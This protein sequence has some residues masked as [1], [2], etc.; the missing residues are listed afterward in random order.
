MKK[1]SNRS[2]FVEKVV[3]GLLTVV[4]LTACADNT[5]EKDSSQVKEGVPV[6]VNLQFQTSTA[7]RVTTRAL[8]EKGEFQV[9]DLYLLIFDKN[10]NRKEGSIYY[11]TEALAGF[12]HTAGNQANPTHGTITNLKTTSGQSY[13]FGIANVADNELDRGNKLKTQLDNMPSLSELKKW[14]TTLNND[15]NIARSSPSLLMSGTFQAT[16]ATDKEKAE[17]ICTIPASNGKISGKLNLRRLDSHITFNIKLGEK[18]QIFEL[19]SWQVY[20][21]PVNSF[22]IDQ[23]TQFAEARYANSGEQKEYSNQSDESVFSFDF[24]MQ[25]NLKRAFTDK[26]TMD[27]TVLTNYKDREKEM[28]NMDGSNSGIYKYVEANATYVEIKAKMNIQPSGDNKF[29]TADVRYIVHLGGGETDYTNFNSLRNKKYTYTVTI[30]DVESIIV[31]VK[32]GE[33]APGARP[34]SEGDVVD[35][36]T[37][38]YALDSHYSCFNMGFTYED[39]VDNLSFIVQTPFAPDAVYSTKGAIGGLA[40]TVQANGDYKWIEF[41]RAED[42]NTLAKYKRDPIGNQTT[43]LT[44]YDLEDDMKKQGKPGDGKTYYYTVFIDEYYYDEAP[45]EIAKSNW[46]NPL[47]KNFVNKGNRKLLLF[48]ETQTS[49]DRESDYSQAKYMIRQKS[50]QTYY[51]TENFND[52]QNALG[53]EHIN[54]TGY[55]DWNGTLNNSLGSHSLISTGWSSVNGF[56]NTNRYFYVLSTADAANVS[57]FERDKW[58]TY[59]DYTISENFPQTYHM[60]DVAAI[61]ECLSRN[62]DENGNGIIDLDE[63][64][65]Y[66][67]STEQ[68]ISVFLGAKSLPSPLFD[69]KSIASVS[70]ND[71]NNHY[72]T[73][74]MQKIWAEEGCSFGRISKYGDINYPKRMRCVRNL[75]LSN[76]LAKTKVVDPP[77]KYNA[78]TRVFDM[79]QLTIQNKRTGKLS[80]EIDSHNNFDDANR[81]YKAFKMASTFVGQGFVTWEEYFDTDPTHRSKCKELNEDG[82]TWRAPNQREFIIMYLQ[83]RTNLVNGTYTAFSCTHWKYDPNRHFGYD[84]RSLFLDPPVSKYYRTI[85][86]VR[87]IDV[88]INGNIIE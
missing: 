82:K 49:E 71:G 13:I 23:N 17:G 60:K 65:W 72:I 39:I 57:M 50:I 9:N 18:I 11:N 14:V 8:T 24:Y 79:S 19:D 1:Q 38:S 61:A 51:S 47:W 25:E 43:P 2:M 12:G 27:G 68:L 3:Y 45:T 87:D 30:V 54:E 31:E 48:L 33:D 88:D 78:G 20:N 85:R 21:V 29:R 59:L 42:K 66:L 83:N 26:E 15:G 4:C 40:N 10:G 77:F 28:K 32:S 73:S 63:L 86:C 16:G 76:T 5:W 6:S 34:G 80:G 70:L 7:E 67:P 56:F 84:G 37:E 64:K 35:A 53:M 69:D 52:E 22:L 46:G 55:P 41:Q 58:D 36:K 74:N 62:R 75:G 44:L 81:P